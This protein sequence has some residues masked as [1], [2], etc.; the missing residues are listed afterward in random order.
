MRRQ[1]QAAAAAVHVYLQGDAKRLKTEA[2]L[3]VAVDTQVGVEQKAEDNV[4]D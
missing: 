2:E 3:V 4:Q 1:D